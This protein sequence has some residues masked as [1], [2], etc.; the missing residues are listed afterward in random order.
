LVSFVFHL[1]FLSRKSRPLHLSHLLLSANGLP[2][3]ES[4]LDFAD[5]VSYNSPCQL[6]SLPTLAP[7]HII[8]H[9]YYGCESLFCARKR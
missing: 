6:S 3:K 7:N 4:H 8:D 5:G 2:W 9:S 1:F